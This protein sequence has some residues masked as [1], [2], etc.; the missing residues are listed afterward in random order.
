M[1]A[2][3]GFAT[4]CGGDNPR[5]WGMKMAQPNYFEGTGNQNREDVVLSN[6]E[7]FA[8]EKLFFSIICTEEA[9]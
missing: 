7:D 8:N 4:Q 6:H 2:H 5:A 9:T 1:V 3:R